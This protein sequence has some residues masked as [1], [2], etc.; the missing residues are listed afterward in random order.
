MLSIRDK[1]IFQINKLFFIVL[2]FI[3]D[4]LFWVLIKIT[5]NKF[6]IKILKMGNFD[7][8]NLRCNKNYKQQ[9]IKIIKWCFIKKED[10]FSRISSCLSRSLTAKVI[11]SILGIKTN[12]FLSITKNKKGKKVPHAW[13]ESNEFKI[14]VTQSYVSKKAA[15]IL[16]I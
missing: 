4:S 10:L 8:L 15:T 13:V 3:V 7:F 2:I 11:L 9:L 14:N 5:P 12:T 1:Y 6:L 16:K